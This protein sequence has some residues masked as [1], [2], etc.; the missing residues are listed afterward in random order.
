MTSPYTL[1]LERHGGFA[2]I[3]MRAEIHSADMTPPEAE[4]LWALAS[5]KDLRAAA[6]ASARPDNPDSFT[7]R[8]IVDTSDH[9]REFSFTESAIGSDVRPL[10][11]RLEHH[12]A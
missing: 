11:D 10:I 6:E 9:R 7:Y 8:L 4:Q 1:I 5:E 2:G 3:G 12:L